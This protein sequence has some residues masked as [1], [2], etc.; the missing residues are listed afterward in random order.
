[1]PKIFKPRIGGLASQKIVKHDDNSEKSNIAA[2]VL[3]TAQTEVKSPVDQT[4]RSSSQVNEVKP[5]EKSGLSDDNQIPTEEPMANVDIDDTVSEI[6]ITYQSYPL[7]PIDLFETKRPTLPKPRQKRLDLENPPPPIDQPLNRSTVTMRSLLNW[8]PVNKP[9]P[10]IRDLKPSS[11]PALLEEPE[12]DKKPTTQTPVDDVVGFDSKDLK[13]V[14][15]DPFAP[16]VRIDADGNIVLD[17][18]SL[19]VQRPDPLQGQARRHVAEETGIY[20]TSYSSFRRPRPG[21][22]SRWNSRENTRFYRALSTIGTDFYCMTKLF[23]KR[24]RSQLLKKYKQEE[25]LH[26]HLVNEALKNKR[27]YDVTCFY[28]SSDEEPYDELMKDLLESKRKINRLTKDKVKKVE[29]REKLT[30]EERAARVSNIIDAVLADTN[31]KNGVS[32]SP[33]AGAASS[34]HSAPSG[35]ETSGFET[36]SSSDRSANQQ[37]MLS[38]MIDDIGS[39]GIEPQ[40][41]PSESTYTQYKNVVI[42]VTPLKPSSV[43]FANPLELIDSRPSDSFLQPNP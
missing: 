13:G 4:L 20:F 34:S 41:E 36:A 16:Q 3:S 14:T 24:T 11:P 35:T 33:P 26:P 22:G 18:T 7:C 2:P 9:P 30:P 31:V 37:T 12:P 42:N 8:V 40:K 28:N 32:L 21:R 17:E 15:L 5:S 23:P 25:R 1:M 29:K 6:S 38:R 39:C 43:S 19:E 27:N 10:K